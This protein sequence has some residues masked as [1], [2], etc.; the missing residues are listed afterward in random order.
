MRPVQ[1]LV[2]LQLVPG[3]RGQGVGVNGAPV[4]TTSL[5]F[6]LWRIYVRQ[7]FYGVVL[8]V[9]SVQLAQLRPFHVFKRRDCVRG[10]AKH[11]Q[12]F[13]TNELR[14][15]LTQL[16]VAHPQSDERLAPADFAAPMS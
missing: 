4:V 2:L 14:W 13:T 3:V 11:L 7:L 9:D 12:V 6:S 10:S 16:I 15:N 5:P 1:A 8:E